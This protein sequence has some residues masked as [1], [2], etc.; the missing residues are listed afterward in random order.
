MAIAIA[1]YWAVS[2]RLWTVKQRASQK[3]Q[4]KSVVDQWFR[5]SKLV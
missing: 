5:C 2:T 3:N 4:E 1:L